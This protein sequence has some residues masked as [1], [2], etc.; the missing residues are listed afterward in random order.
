MKTV[1]LLD[2]GMG[3]ELIRRSGKSPSPLWSAQIMLDMPELVEQLHLDFIR[4][5]ST[6]ITVNTYSATPERLAL[7]GQRDKFDALQAAAGAVALSA[8]EKSGVEGIRIAGCLPPLVASYHPELAP[9]KDVSLQNYSKIVAAQSPYVD[10]FVCETMASKNESVYAATAAL[11]SGKPVWIA[12]TLDDEKATCLRGGEPWQEA[13]NAVQQ[14][15]VDAI[16]LNCSRP[17]TI[18]EVWQQFAAGCDVPVGAYANCFNAVTA[19]KPGGTVDSL[20]TR[21]DLGPEAY[22]KFA[23]DWVEKGATLIGGCCGV[24]PAQIA[25]LRQELSELTASF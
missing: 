15:G 5:G 16:L 20:E 12:L 24:A 1:T 3:Q 19:L 4:A 7:Q 2:G 9:P 17:E 22:A 25:R 10:L 23:M 13:A 6:V 11:E 21:Q 18:S 14:M 8:R